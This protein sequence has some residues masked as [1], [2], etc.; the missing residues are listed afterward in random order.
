M[1]QPEFIPIDID[2]RFQFQC[3]RDVPCFNQCC[4]DLNQ[5]LTPYDVLIL[6]KYLDLSWQAFK[7][8]YAAVHIGPT[9]GLPVVSLRFDQA[10]GKRCPFVSDQG[11]RVYT[12]RPSS[13]RLYPLA[14]ALGRS[15][16]TGRVTVHYALLQEPHCRGFEQGARITA[17]QWI[18][19][20][21]LALY[22]SANDALLELIAIKNRLG[23]GPLPPTQQQWVQMALYD[24]DA[25]KQ[26]AASD[27]LA[28]IAG[29]GVDPPPEV[30][31]D[32][33]WLAW[34]MVWIKRVLTLNL[35][36]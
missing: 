4:R 28:G 1:T 21:Q 3:H 11:C 36:C 7:D 18:A 29:P 13:C 2:H 30:D 34:G 6:R 26:H 32:G 25:L 19:D 16:D 14:R 9:T 17:G 20:Q 12:A 23:K 31:D 8:A 27:Q 33:Q 24:L 15:S 10:D 35:K 5:A 22:F